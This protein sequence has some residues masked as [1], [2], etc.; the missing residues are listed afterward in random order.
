MTKKKFEGTILAIDH[1]ES[2]GPVLERFKQYVQPG[3]TL[4]LEY[5]EHLLPEKLSDK[6]WRKVGTWGKV[7]DFCLDNKMKVVALDSQKINK[8]ETK[9][10]QQLSEAWEKIG[11]TAKKFGISENEYRSF[12]VDYG[13][14]ELRERS[15][16]IKLRNAKHGDI[17]VM[18]PEHAYRI[19][20]RLG[21]ER[22]KVVWLHG[23]QSIKTR[24]IEK[25]LHWR[26]V[27]K[28]KKL[29]NALREQRRQER[30]KPK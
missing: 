5:P 26:K 1:W 17:V 24:D 12:S 25:V 27:A 28:I 9:L 7:V 4:Y 14:R 23:Y 15:W 30:K 29:R 13:M 16:A 10:T 20:P 6:L 19:A 8:I 21:I 22:K 18:H 3:K 11:E 2:L